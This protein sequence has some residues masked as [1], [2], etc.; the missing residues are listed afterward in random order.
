MTPEEIE[1]RYKSLINR[2]LK[3][4]K[5]FDEFVDSIQDIC[6]HPKKYVNTYTIDTDD[7]YGNWYKEKRN[8]CSVCRKDC[9]V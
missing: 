1:K 3:I 7:G 9:S 4:D 5:D 2:E 8:Y 6:H